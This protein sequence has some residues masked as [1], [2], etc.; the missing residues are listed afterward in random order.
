M[1]VASKPKVKLLEVKSVSRKENEVWHDLYKIRVKV[2]DTEHEFEDDLKNGVLK[3]CQSIFS[4]REYDYKSFDYDYS[5]N[6]KKSKRMF[7]D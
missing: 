4:S 5:R 1:T 6:P 2:Q 7:G 3:A